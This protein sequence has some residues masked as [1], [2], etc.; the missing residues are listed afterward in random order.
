MILVTGASGL[1]GKAIAKAALEHGHEVRVQ[2]RNKASFLATMS[3]TDTTRLEVRE[4]D[5]S[6]SSERELKALVSECDAVVHLA[7]VVHRPD[8]PYEE[9]EL[10]N[11]RTTQSLA[12]FAQESKAS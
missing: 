6:K 9:Y 11:V 10:V 1:I 4:C 12:E 8:A 3:G 5:F 2:V 7:A